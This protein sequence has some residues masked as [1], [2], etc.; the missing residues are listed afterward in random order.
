LNFRLALTELGMMSDTASLKIQ[1]VPCYVC[2]AAAAR[3]TY[4]PSESKVEEK[5]AFGRI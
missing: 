5:R 3:S 2:L 1:I 4:F